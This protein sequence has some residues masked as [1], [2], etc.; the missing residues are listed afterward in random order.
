MVAKQQRTLVAKIPL[1]PS[2]RIYAILARKAPFAVLFRRGPSKQVLTIGWDTQTHEFRM[3]QWFKGRLYERRCDL[4]PSGEKLVRDTS[5]NIGCWT[6]TGASR[7]I[8]GAV[9]GQIGPDQESCSSLARVV[10]IES[11]SMASLARVRPRS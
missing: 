5:W 11:W 8:W 7:S 10:S 6:R 9:T 2:I 1:K 4:S 3:G